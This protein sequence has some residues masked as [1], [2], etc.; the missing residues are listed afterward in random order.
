MAAVLA[1]GQGAVLSHRSAAALWSFVGGASPRI[2]VTSVGY[3]GAVIRRIRHHRVR[4]LPPEETTTVDEIPVTTVARTLFDLAEVLAPHRLEG[5]FE[6]AEREELLDMR[7]V[8]LTAERNPGRR[9]H[10][11]LRT[12]LPR[13]TA[14]STTRAELER[15]FSRMC[16][17]AGLPLPQMNV[18]VEGLEVDALWPE[19]RLVV[20]VDGWE[21]HKTR[22]AFER[23]RA[24][25]AQLLLAGYRVVRVTYLQLRDGPETVADTLRRLIAAPAW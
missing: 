14:P 13:L 19:Q 8:A 1:C 18:L 22:A 20:E 15:T 3:R 5:A 25:D 21:F 23:D 16:R 6:A 2:D 10:K 9:A 17:L 7:E 4:R 12:L 11:R 24:R